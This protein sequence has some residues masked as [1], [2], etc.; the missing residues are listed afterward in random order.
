MN[1]FLLSL[2]VILPLSTF[3]AAQE[4]NEEETVEEIVTTG[5]KSSLKDAIDIKRNNVGVMEA[6]TAEDFGKFPDGNLA[7]S[8]ARIAGVAIDR[9]N[10]EGEGV[11]VRGFGPELNLV[12]LN[13]RQMPTVPGQWGGGRSFNFGDI[14]SP[15]VA[16]VE[17][18]KSTNNSLPSGGIGSTINMVTTKP[19]NIDGTKFSLSA[20]M[21]ND[22]TSTE[23]ETPEISLLYAINGGHWGFAFSGSHQERQNREEGTRE[24]NWLIPSRM[25]AIEGYNRTSTQTNVTDNNARTDGVTFYQEPTAY[26]IKD[27]DRLRKNAQVTFQLMPNDRNVTTLDYTYSGVDFSSKGMMFGSWLGGWD[28]VSGTINSNGVY[29]DVQAA[30][31]SYDHELIWGDTTNANRSFGI[32]HEFTVSDSL[33]VTFDFHDSMALKSG[34]ELPNSIGIS[35]AKKSTITH[36]NGGKGGINTFAYDKTYT[37]AD[38]YLSGLNLSDAYKKNEMDQMQLKAEWVN[39]DGGIVTAVDFGVSQTT[40]RFSDARGQQSLSINS[41]DAA[42]FDD[43][44]FK[45]TDLGSFMSAFSPVIGTS[46]YFDVDEDEALAA[47]AAAGGP[48]SNNFGVDSNE[49]V[50]EDLD[51]AFI[52][53]QME[54]LVYGKPLNIIAGVRYE[55]SST[56]STSLEA[57]PDTIRLDFIS[58]VQYLAAGGII[59]APRSGST[60]DVLP[61]LAMSYALSDN[62]VL[63]FS[64]SKTIAR[65]SLQDKRSQLSYGS[66]DFWNPTAS[67]GN[68]NLESLKSNNYDLAYENYYAEGS[69][70][71]ANYFR[72]EISDFVGSSTTTG[73]VN[74]ITNPAY[75]DNVMAARACMQDW[76]TAGR[77]DTVTYGDE[78]SWVYCV[79]QQ[80]IWGQSWMNDNQHAMWVALAKAANGGTLPTMFNNGWAFGQSWSNNVCN[81]GGWWRCNPGYIDGTSADPLAL[82]TITKP[83]N[84]EEGTVS[85]L[86]VTVQHFFEGTPYGMQFNATK[87][88]GGDV[89]VDRDSVESQFMLPGFGDSAN[90]SFFYEDDK[91]TFRVAANHRG[92]TL[93]GFGNYE[94][95]LYVEARTQI[96]ATYQY[97]ATANTTVFLDMM[98]INDES[99]RLHAR[100]SEMLFLSQDHGPIVKFGFRAN[101]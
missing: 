35:S 53:V 84:L 16:A 97:R 38:M 48:S 49:R 46:Y 67:G 50:A 59:D 98:N 37:P 80:A 15:G 20:G 1:K 19:L 36:T 99:T 2:M 23:G 76:V 66:S 3:V 10:V 24:A 34:S 44:L 90:L 62:E 26:Q 86:E 69:Y 8:L 32:N 96:D 55:E 92:E 27:N 68:P 61:S 28:T 75:G 45:T 47:W 56:V 13:G 72:K 74:G 94:Q 18:Y 11:A 83:T 88:T 33:V 6:I 77:P 4:A 85:G 100:Y 30:L 21:V 41:P 93:A 39:L 54:T 7:E 25:A 95:P 40:S 82:F 43:S 58:G 73:N 9:S 51:S 57:R 12:T 64:A 22:S 65:P 70:F 29:T 81:D 5:I 14:A 78:G 79:S 60:E 17:L 31:R 101:F 89:E 91:H 71:A 87:V 42:A 63:R 52:Q